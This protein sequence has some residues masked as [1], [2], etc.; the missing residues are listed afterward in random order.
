MQV[1]L[2]TGV[3]GSGKSTIGKILSKK[4]NVPYY[5]ADDFHPDSNIQKMKNSIPLF[6]ADRDSWLDE[7]AKKIKEWNGKEGAVL[8]CSAL[9]EK[10]RKHLQTIPMEEMTWIFLHADYDVIYDRIKNRKNHYF[11]AE[12]LHTQYEALET[13]E[14]GI[15]VNVDKSIPEII[16]EILE[17]IGKGEKI[18]KG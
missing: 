2:V 17:K 5:D 15:H 8:A 14:Y 16:D 1:Y 13:P 18:Q 3:S 6:D 7:L 9:K 12:L 11:K 10:Y 4:I